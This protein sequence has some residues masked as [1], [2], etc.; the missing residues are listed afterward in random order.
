MGFVLVLALGRKKINEV[1]T[2]RNSRV[3]NDMYI[4]RYKLESDLYRSV[5]G[6]MH[7]FLF[8]SSGNG[9]SW[10]YK[11]TFAQ[12]KVN[13]VVANCANASRKKSLTMEIVA[14]CQT[15]EPLKKEVTSTKKGGVSA[16]GKAEYSHQT[17]YICAQEDEL[18]MAFKS[19]SKKN[20]K[21]VIVLDNVESIFKD[22]ELMCELSDILILLDDEVYAQY[23]I[24]I[25]IVGVPYEVFKYFNS[26]KNTTSV[27]NRIEELPRVAGLGHIHVSELVKRGFKKYLKANLT[28][29]ELDQISKHTFDVTFGVPQRVHEFCECLA[30]QLEDQSWVFHQD[31]LER[32]NEAWLKKGLRESY[33][34]IESHLNSIETIDGRRNQ[35]IYAIGKHP[36]DKIST[37]SIANIVKKEFPLSSPSK[38]S[39]VGQVLA[40]L[41]KGDTPLLH[42]NEKSKSYSICDVRHLM[43]I[44]VMLHKQ[45]MTEIVKKKGFSNN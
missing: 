19:L 5:M 29:S 16:I 41:A 31:M 40:Y 9:K 37:K 8:G 36:N 28:D 22:D 3:N 2:P 18:L 11:K 24:K 4:A 43:C 25:L 13:Y 7:S 23:N 34:I 14:V 30:Y 20:S 27:G 17:R 10:L 42:K 39:G 12:K 26:A 21:S 35:V 44:R 33:T 32:A 15:E 6:S 45:P 1:F 38:N